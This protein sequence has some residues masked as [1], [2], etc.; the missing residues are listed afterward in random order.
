MILA[1]LVLAASAMAALCSA[2]KLAG[3][4]HETRALNREIARL[5]VRREG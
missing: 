4:M 1:C 2:V 5:R 3:E